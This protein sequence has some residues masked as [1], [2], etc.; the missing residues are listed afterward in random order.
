M[1]LFCFSSSESSTIALGASGFFSSSSSFF[2][3]LTGAAGGAGTGFLTSFFTSA[4]GF[5]AYFASATSGFFSAG[6]SSDFLAVSVFLTASAFLAAG[7]GLAFSYDF[8]TSSLLK[9][10]FLVL[11]SLLSTSAVAHWSVLDLTSSSST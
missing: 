7:A 4:F 10:L 1:Y 6:L 5:S 11:N 9:S 8:F 2:S 3:V